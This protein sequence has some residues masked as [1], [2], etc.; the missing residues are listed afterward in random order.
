MKRQPI[1]VLVIPFRRRKNTI[2]YCLLKRSDANYWQFVAGGVESGES[3]MEAAA[4]EVYE[5]VGT[6]L[7][8]KMISLDSTCSMPA[9]IF[10]DWEKWPKGTYLVKECAFAVEVLSD[11]IKLSGEHTEFC[12]VS[13]DEAMKLLKWDSNKTALWELSQ[14]LLAS[15][16]PPKALYEIDGV[17]IRSAKLEDAP[18]IANVHLNAWRESYKGQLDQSFLDDMPLSFK[19]RKK[20]WEE[21][22][23]SHADRVFVAESKH[24]II[25]FNSIKTPGREENMKDWAE[26]GAIYLL[27]KFK[28][29]KIGLHLLK[30]GFQS[31]K[32]NGYSKAY[33]WM[34]KGNRTGK[35]YESTGAKLSGREKVEPINGKDEVDVMYIWEKIE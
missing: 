7:E 29:K 30:A 34:L 26:V 27:E 22:I 15:S 24:G 2:E 10:K 25:G 14:R 1:Q 17:Q 6:P 20:N 19:R 4:R 3:Q 28:G 16:Q 13:F 12:W 11:S 33:C 8:A 5:E 35:F 31:M 21:Y 9:N 23:A 32:S 18:E